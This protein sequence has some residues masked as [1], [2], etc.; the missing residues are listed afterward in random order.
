M[1]G[2]WG[3]TTPI[4]PG[5]YLN[6][7]TTGTDAVSAGNSGIVGLPITSDWG[8]VGEFVEVSSDAQYRG[9]FGP[10]NYGKSYLVQ[11]AFRG[12]ALRVLAFRMADPTTVAAS[13]LDITDNAATYAVATTTPGA[14]G[15]DEVQEL[16]ATAAANG[17]DFTLT[18]T[19][20]VASPIAAE[21]TAPIPYN[22][23][24]ADVQTALEALPSIEPGDVTV[25]GGPMPGTP[26]VITFTGGTTAAY[27]EADMAQL[28]VNSAGLAGGDPIMTLDAKYPGTRGDSIRVVIRPNPLDNAR[29]DVHVYEGSELREKYTVEATDHETL[30]AQIND[31]T[32]GSGLLTATL[33][34]AHPEYP[35]TYTVELADSLTGTYLTGGDNGDAGLTAA[36]YTDP[37]GVFDMFE[38]RGGFDVF[39]LPDEAD[40][41][42]VSSLIGWAQSMNDEGNYV[43][44]VVGGDTDE[45][46]ATAVSRSGSADSE[47][48]V[49]VGRTDLKVWYPDG[50]SQIRRTA[51]MTA[52][53]AGQIAAAGINRAITFA[54]M[55]TADSPVEVVTPLTRDEIEEAITSGVVIFTKRGSRVV[56][57]DGVT[58][59]TSFTTERDATFGNIK[60]VR[61]MQQIG[62][63]FNEIIERGFI[64]VSNNNAATRSALIT[65]VKKYLKG[66][67]DQGA[68]VNGSQVLLD[69]RFINTGDTVHLLLLVQFGRELK[70]VLMTLRAPI[71]T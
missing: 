48:I 22:A 20:T 55:S 12:G 53:V 1:G 41:A 65:A 43:Q 58:T 52:R 50:T 40:P 6:F 45:L 59:F 38:R 68:L 61:T 21:T 25:T 28:T 34:T 31:P 44:V 49:N 64:G 57:E 23:S 16:S 35:G 47:W 19:G 15:T 26:I 60:S 7:E 37:L 24:A 18:F 27:N 8:P 30:V 62:R 32:D 46:L 36:D 56:I 2:I 13:T 5:L 4:R 10:N 33:N 14:A 11:E 71:L 54:D 51:A 69:E 17:G 70:R 39:T 3:S 29:K 63:D 42:L 66:L 9:V 67:E